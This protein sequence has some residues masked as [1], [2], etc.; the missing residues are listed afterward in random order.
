MDTCNCMTQGVERL[1][2]P[3]YMVCVEVNSAV[4]TACIAPEKCATVYA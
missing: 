3:D 2:I 4:A 1:N